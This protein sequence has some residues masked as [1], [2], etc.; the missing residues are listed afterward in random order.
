M[1][2]VCKRDGRRATCSLMSSVSGIYH[3]ESLV[4]A[5]LHGAVSISCLQP[6]SG[7]V[8]VT[9]VTFWG[10]QEHCIIFG[11]SQDCRKLRNI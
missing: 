2:G 4:I 6:V 1:L 7:Q 10:S 8:T 5:G 3:S 11:T 9:S